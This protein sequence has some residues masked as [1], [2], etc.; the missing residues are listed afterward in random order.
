MK[1]TFGALPARFPAAKEK[2][3][4]VFLFLR[5]ILLHYP[6]LDIFET[7]CSDQNN[8][9]CPYIV[10]VPLDFRHCSLESASCFTS[11]PCEY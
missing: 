8:R 2:W 9:F 1:T 10:S 4:G 7:I 5:K 11:G 6:G 3:H